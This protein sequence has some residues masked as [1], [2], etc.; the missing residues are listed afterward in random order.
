ML[1]VPFL[2]LLAVSATQA[3]PDRDKQ[4]SEIISVPGGAI[5][6]RWYGHAGRT[7]F[8]QVSDPNN[9]LAKWTWLPA[10]ES[11]N[12]EEI[13]H[14]VGGTAPQVFYRLR[15]T[16]L[17]IPSGKTPETADFDNDGLS[18]LDEIAPPPPLLATDPLDPDTDHDGLTDG[19]ERSFPAQML[20]L[21]SAAGTLG[22]QLAI[23][24]IWKPRPSGQTPE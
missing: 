8:I 7:Y 14:V 13:S 11:G 6:H 17:P 9:P 23:P 2:F 20:A 4:E 16:D 3:Q 19:W 10:I 1:N 21:G 15:P 5:F 22:F 12:N 24:P 18:N